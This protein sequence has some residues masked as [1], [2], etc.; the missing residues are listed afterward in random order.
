MRRALF[1]LLLA[2]TLPAPALA[3]GADDLVGAWY[4]L[5]HYQDSAT[6][7]AD[8]KRWEDRIWV[9]EKAGDQLRW[10]DYPIVVFDD[11]QYYMGSIIAEMLRAAGRK[12]TIVSP[13]AEVAAWSYATMETKYVAKHLAD[14]L[15]G[16]RAVERAGRIM[17]G[18]EFITVFEQ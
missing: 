16:V 17:H 5:V 4:V 10:T 15:C 6:E 2:A 13:A 18:G 9:F 3:I 7:N 12:V 1:A 11:D 14:A 8:A